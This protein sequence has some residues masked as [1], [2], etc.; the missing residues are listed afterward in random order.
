MTKPSMLF[1][2]VWISAAFLRRPVGGLRPH[3][4]AE[5]KFESFTRSKSE[6]REVR[7]LPSALFSAP[8]V[9]VMSARWATTQHGRVK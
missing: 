8:N 3:A 5:Q 4:R 9:A 2:G 7:F 6:R 1:E